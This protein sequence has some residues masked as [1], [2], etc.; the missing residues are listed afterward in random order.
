[1]K[2]A[3]GHIPT[4]IVEKTFMT[5]LKTYLKNL[6]SMHLMK[7]QNSSMSRVGYLQKMVFTALLH[8]G[9]KTLLNTGIQKKKSAEKV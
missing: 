1:M 5:L 3:L 6:G 9:P 2:T 4:L 8:K 7:I